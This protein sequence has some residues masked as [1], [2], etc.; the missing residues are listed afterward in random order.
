MLCF[1][2]FC[3]KHLRRWK[4]FRRSSCGRHERKVK[5]GRPTD[6]PCA[7]ACRRAQGGRYPSRGRRF[8]PTMPRSALPRNTECS[9]LRGLT[10]GATSCPSPSQR[11]SPTYS[12]FRAAP[13][14]PPCKMHTKHTMRTFSAALPPLPS[15]RAMLKAQWG[16]TDGDAADDAG[17]EDKGADADCRVQRSGEGR[18]EGKVGRP[19]E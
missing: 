7:R 5:G 13:M 9:I 17:A 18:R 6:R 10:W 16:G 1:F 19:S 2:V 11:K 15:A 8:T 14:R 3:V 4:T 12:P